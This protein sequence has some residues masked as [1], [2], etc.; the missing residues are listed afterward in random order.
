[1]NKQSTHFNLLL[2]L[3]IGMTSVQICSAQELNATLTEAL[4]NVTV[5]S[6]AGNPPVGD[7]IWFVPEG[8]EEGYYGVTNETGKFSMLIANGVTYEA[9]FKNSQGQIQKASI[10]IPGNEKI[11]FDFKLNYELPRVYTLD[12]VF[13]A[14]GKAT[15]T[16]AS[17]AELNELIEV[18]KFKTAMKIEIGGHTDDVGE[19]A[20][21][22]K[23]S[24]NRANAVRNYLIKKG[25]TGDRVSAVGYGESKPVAYN[26]TP[27]GRQKNR[28]TEVRILSQ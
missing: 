28:R 23:L 17:F 5:V 8:A 14:T 16:T 18:M 6:E 22:Q 19:D 12:Q 4:L 2:A 25:I 20:A 11:V 15:L 26:N 3:I 24:Q 9:R 1:M 10:P 27:E 7:T 13:F 21:N